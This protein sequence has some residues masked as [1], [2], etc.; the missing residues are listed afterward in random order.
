L[1]ARSNKSLGDERRA[2]PNRDQRASD[3]ESLAEPVGSIIEAVKVTLEHTAPEL[4][5]D[6]VDKGIMLTGG[7]AL[8]AGRC[9]GLR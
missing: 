2:K 8:L 5:A 6:I 1:R 9:V 7:G 3:S 4:V